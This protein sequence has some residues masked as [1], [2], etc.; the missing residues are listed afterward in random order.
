MKGFPEPQAAT[1]PQNGA[2][3]YPEALYDHERVVCVDVEAQRAGAATQLVKVDQ[4]LLDQVIAALAVGL[5]A[6]VRLQGSVVAL[7]QQL[8]EPQDLPHVVLVV[9]QRLGRG[10]RVPAV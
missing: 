6:D 1:T 7:A 4:G 8:Q 5:L 3:A 10:G 9:R 2:H